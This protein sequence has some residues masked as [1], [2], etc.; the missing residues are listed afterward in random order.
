MPPRERAEMIVT[1]TLLDRLRDDAPRY[2][3][4]KASMDAYR[5]SVL[6]DIEWLLNTRRPPLPEADDFDH[7]SRSVIVYG[8]V[9]MHSFDGSIGRDA[10]ALRQSL[11]Q[12]LRAFE[13]RIQNLR[14]LPPRKDEFKRSL[15]FEIEGMLRYDTVSE[16]IS[17]D[18][19]LDL[20]EGRYQVD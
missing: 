11:E 16:P 4:R 15:N 12:T 5:E 17:F 18:T 1:P 3:T 14:I 20:I 19:V 7:A 13:P 6:R 9:D 8:L 10:A 2:S